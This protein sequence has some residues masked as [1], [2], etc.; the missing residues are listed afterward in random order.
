MQRIAVRGLVRLADLV[1]RELGQPV[2]P[3][4]LGVL[5]ERIAAGTGVVDD[6]LAE[7]GATPD[8]LPT[9][10]RRAYCYLKG[11]DLRSASTTDSP[12]EPAREPAR[13]RLVG[14]R[15]HLDRVLD[16]VARA[17]PD[18]KCDDVFSRIV[19]TSQGIAEHLQ[20]NEIQTEQLKIESRDLRAW[21]DYFSQGAHFD[22][23]V[24]AVRMAIGELEKQASSSSRI[25]LPAVVHFRPTRGLYRVRTGQTGTHLTLPTP[26]IAFDADG[27]AAL[28]RMVAGRKSEKRGLIER[29]ESQAYVA[30]RRELDALSG[31]HSS[32][33][34]V[35]HD[36]AASF[37]RVNARYFEGTMPRPRLSWS[38]QITARKFGHYDSIED[39]VMLSR[40]I[41]A[42]DVPEYVVD[43]VMYHELLHIKHGAK[44]QGGRRH[45]HTP[46]FRRDERQFHKYAEAREAIDR[47]AMRHR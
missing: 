18:D 19:E 2:T 21:F 15:S 22:R 34:S 37:A 40:T 45:V 17:E 8:A 12:V 28:A 11:L 9:P 41:D 42:A 10:S 23:Y 4:R 38:R 33:G 20:E 36:L 30:L 29:T 7:H 25:P 27:F 39:A 6:L 24:V 26:M 47:L 3:A 32:P 13:I 31:L 44:W 5:G 46:E 1:R 43:F 16:D 35:S 14:L